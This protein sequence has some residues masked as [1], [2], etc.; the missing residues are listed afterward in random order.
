MAVKP[1]TAS[2]PSWPRRRCSLDVPARSAS[3]I[4]CLHRLLSDKL[5]QNN[6][7]CVFVEFTNFVTINPAIAHFVLVNTPW[8]LYW[9]VNFVSETDVSAPD[10]A[11][12]GACDMP[13]MKVDVSRPTFTVCQRY[14]AKLMVWQD[15]CAHLAQR[16]AA[17]A[18]RRHQT[19]A[20]NR[21]Q[22]ELL[23]VLFYFSSYFYPK[24]VQLC[25]IDECLWCNVS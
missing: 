20:L 5:P 3:S 15:G 12:A 11:R 8:I 10:A 9:R 23:V 21:E 2:W 4:T 16:S 19:W 25:S 22:I 6:Q 14:P 13:R 18:R 24:F 7:C 1:F 17:G